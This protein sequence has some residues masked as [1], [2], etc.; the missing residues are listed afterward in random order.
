MDLKESEL[1]GGAIETHWYYASKAEAVEAMLKGIEFSQ[2][3]D[4]GAGSGFFSRRLLRRAGTRSATC[5]DPFYAAEREETVQGKPLRFVRELDGNEGDLLLFMDVLEHVDR[6]DALLGQYVEAA[7]PGTYVLISV[8]AFEFLWSGHDV[9]LGHHRRYRLGQL[10]RVVS[11]AGLDILN[12]HYYF[13]GVFPAALMT[14][15]IGR[16]LDRGQAPASQLR[17]HGRLTNGVLRTICRLEVPLMGFN[18]L[19]GLTVFC[20]A[21]KPQAAG[22][23]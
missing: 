8:P 11:A 12:S 7:P 1:L 5:V 21:Q 18:R 23:S 4:V 22:Q 10:R 20:L 15:L 3:V 2:I 14:R 16:L 6:D 9:Y 17:V 19:A 13:G